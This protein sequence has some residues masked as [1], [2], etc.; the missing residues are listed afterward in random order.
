MFLGLVNGNP[1]SFNNKHRENVVLHDI[2][3]SKSKERTKNIIKI[4][5]FNGT[6][7]SDAF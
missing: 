4:I 2:K 5:L 6:Q 1:T 3:R 7:P